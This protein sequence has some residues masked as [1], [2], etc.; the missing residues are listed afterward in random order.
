MVAALVFAGLEQTVGQTAPHLV[1]MLDSSACAMV[2]GW[3]EQTVAARAVHSV[4]AWADSWADWWVAA[5]AVAT[6]G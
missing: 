3:A 4:V 5:L 6:A 2:A 1:V